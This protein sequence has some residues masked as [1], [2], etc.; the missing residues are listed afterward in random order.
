MHPLH[1][2]EGTQRDCGPTGDSHLT[3]HSPGKKL[4]VPWKR[5][6]AS[7]STLRSCFRVS[8]GHFG[9]QW[10]LAYLRTECHGHFVSR[11]AGLGDRWR[12]A[13][14]KDGRWQDGDDRTAMAGKMP[15]KGSARCSP[16]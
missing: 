5:L 1:L 15:C 11:G 3:M 16:H 9:Y 8:F 10:T 4:L 13:V 2:L 14:G 7:P 6:G 12:P